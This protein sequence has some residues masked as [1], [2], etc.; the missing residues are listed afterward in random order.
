MVNLS[1]HGDREHQEQ[2]D[3]MQGEVI[4]LAEVRQLILHV[5]SAMAQVDALLVG[6]QE[7]ACTHT[8]ELQLVHALL[9]MVVANAL[10]AM[11]RADSKDL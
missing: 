5:E 6:V 10:I 1:H 9:A 4:A 7:L 2:G 11:V 3:T 8:A